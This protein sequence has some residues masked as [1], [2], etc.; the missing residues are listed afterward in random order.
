[1]LMM[2]TIALIMSGCQEQ[3][4]V[5]DH[6]QSMFP[7]N[8][9]AILIEA[10]VPSGTNNSDDIYITGEFNANE[11]WKME[12]A[13]QSDKK[14]GIYLFPA[15][16]AEG[17]T[18]QDGFY[19]VSKKD[20]EERNLKGDS[21]FHTLDATI[22]KTYNVWIDRWASYFGPKEIEHDG[23]VIYILNEIEEWNDVYVYGYADGLPELFGAWPGKK[24][25][26]LETI[27]GVEYRYVDCGK[28]N[29]GLT[30]NLIFNDGNSGDGHQFNGPGFT[31]DGKTFFRLKADHSYETF[32]PSDEPAGHDGAVVYILDGKNWGANITLYMWGDVNN[33]DT[34]G[35]ASAGWPG[36]P[37]MGFETIGEHNWYYIDLGAANVGKKEA[38]IFSNNGSGQLG[39][40]TDYEITDQDLYVYLTGS[41]PVIVEDPLNIDPTWEIFE[42][43]TTEK[44]DAIID[45]YFYDA[46]TDEFHSQDT[47]GTEGVAFTDTVAALN[48]YAW[49]AKEIFGPWPGKIVTDWK[50]TEI[51]GIRLYHYQIE[52][53]VGDEFNIIVNNQNITG[54]K[55]QYDAFKAV[56]TEVEN[57]YYMKVTNTA[58]TPLELTVKAPRR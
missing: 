11:L 44:E 29:D 36:L 17:K 49:G 23:A 13:E 5:F 32:T 9:K 18:L 40:I 55:Y 45:L 20:G 22:G 14:W 50:Y 43:G 10:I 33:L 52:C 38:L 41:A 27:N 30:Y 15:E 58:A 46:T 8:E 1:M 19:F 26:G 35:G 25:N 12:K 6:E 56:A 28:D 34:K 7:I 24:V 21:V 48:V 16:F 42:A 54:A 53:K 2:A 37:V 39:D 47:L 57:D 3:Q 4:V 31:V 51:L